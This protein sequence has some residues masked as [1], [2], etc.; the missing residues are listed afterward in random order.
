MNPIEANINFYNAQTGYSSVPLS[1]TT[2]AET[3]L[4]PYNSFVA[5]QKAAVKSDSGLTYN[6]S[7]PVQRKRS[8]DSISPF[9]SFPAAQSPHKNC[10]SFSFLGEDMSLHIQRQELDIDRLICQHVS[11][12][13]LQNFVHKKKCFAFQI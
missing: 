7:V 11:I 3:L 10:A 2:T 13:V 12:Y 8:R 1:G 5:D 4:P 6:V 9:I